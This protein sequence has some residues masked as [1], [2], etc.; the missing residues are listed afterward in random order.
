MKKSTKKFLSFLVVLVFAGAI[1]AII[2]LLVLNKDDDDDDDNGESPETNPPDE[3]AVE[4]TEEW[5]TRRTLNIVGGQATEHNFSKSELFEDVNGDN[6]DEE[7]DI[8]D[9]KELCIGKAGEIEGDSPG[10]VCAIQF[11]GVGF[12]EGRP[13]TNIC[14]VWTD[15][16]ISSEDIVDSG[17]GEETL[18]TLPSLF[19]D[20]PNWASQVGGGLAQSFA[21]ADED[22]FN[23]KYR[24]V[25]KGGTP[26]RVVTYD[27]YLS[28]AAGLGDTFLEIGNR[29]V[30]K[31]TANGR[32]ALRAARGLCLSQ[33]YV[34]QSEISGEIC[35]INFYP[36]AFTAD[37][38][39]LSTYDQD[40]PCQIFTDCTNDPGF[41]SA[42]GE[43]E[44]IFAAPSLLC[45][46]HIIF[47]TTG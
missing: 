17:P 24:F 2:V 13:E 29:I 3:D 21:N 33:A 35:G 26:D 9:A 10:S 18:F 16:V 39:N 42:E 38:A 14:R 47:P 5:N 19:C 45:S 23:Q 43:S 11:S 27:N 37:H 20:R 46:N 32:A 4:V 15:C 31:S 1:T 6:N 7:D 44:T 34:F 36:D 41:E 30:D 22:E 40:N 12:D 28:D 8:E 25:S